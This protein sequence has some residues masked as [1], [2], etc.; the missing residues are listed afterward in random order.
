M[1]F[2]PRKKTEEHVEVLQKQEGIAWSKLSKFWPPCATKLRGHTAV[3][4][5]FQPAS[6]LTGHGEK[7]TMVSMTLIPAQLYT[8]L[9]PAVMERQPLQ[10]RLRR[11]TWVGRTRPPAQNRRDAL[12][13]YHG[14]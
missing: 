4:C 1:Y 10:S 7:S 11:T 6:S 2:L 5:A 9:I 12:V 13:V 8:S 14:A 3:S